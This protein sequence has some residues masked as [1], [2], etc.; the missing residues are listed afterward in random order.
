MGLF[1]NPFFKQSLKIM[2][3]IIIFLPNKIIDRKRTGLTKQGSHGPFLQT[4]TRC[5]DPLV[6]VC[7][8]LQVPQENKAELSLIPHPKRVN[9]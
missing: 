2:C 9:E 1:L 7:F 5:R 4:R 6:F 3:N 8:F